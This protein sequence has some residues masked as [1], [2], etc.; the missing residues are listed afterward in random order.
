MYIFSSNLLWTHNVKINTF[1]SN[2]SLYCNTSFVCILSLYPGN[3]SIFYHII[4]YGYYLIF[5]LSFFLIYPC[6]SAII[7]AA[8]WLRLSLYLRLNKSTC[9]LLLPTPP[10]PFAVQ[11]K[12][13]FLALTYLNA[14][15]Q[16][17]EISLL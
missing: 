15:I 14:F 2:P 13:T 7:K 5:I 9:T 16:A 3:N 1:L 11:Q 12:R 10:M 6:H 17:L 8:A 4:K